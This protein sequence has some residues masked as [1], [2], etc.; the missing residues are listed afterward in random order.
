[1]PYDELILREKL[2]LTS[3]QVASIPE[4]LR[5]FIRELLAS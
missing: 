1:M 4:Y 2:G 5:V 3:E